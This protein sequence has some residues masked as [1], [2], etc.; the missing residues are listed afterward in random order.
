MKRIIACLTFV[1]LFH[2]APQAVASKM[3][4]ADQMLYLSTLSSSEKIYLLRLTENAVIEKQKAM[5]SDPENKKDTFL[6]AR[7]ISSIEYA[8]LSDISKSLYLDEPGEYYLELSKIFSKHVTGEIDTK[9]LFKEDERIKTELKN[10]MLSHI[11]NSIRPSRR[12]VS[13]LQNMAIELGDKIHGFS[14]FA[15]SDKK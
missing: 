1:L 9:K 11:D 7:K 4:T 5:F 15:L 2:F 3:L 12:T 14:V 13:T 8:A 6:W 10:Y